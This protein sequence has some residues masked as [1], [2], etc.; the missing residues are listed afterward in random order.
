ML[1]ETE[2]SREKRPRIP[3][4]IMILAVD[5]EQREQ[6][7]A[8]VEK[9]QITPKPGR[10]LGVEHFSAAEFTLNSPLGN[11]RVGIGCGTRL[12]FG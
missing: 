8:N 10:F 4:W 2:A 12:G 6:L 9:S 7:L 1:N 3:T 5:K 11:G